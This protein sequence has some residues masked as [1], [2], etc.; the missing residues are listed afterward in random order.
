MTARDWLDWH[1]AYE[2]PGSALSAR[3][4]VVQAEVRRWLDE[5]AGRPSRVVSACAGDGRDL[6]EVLAER[7]AAHVRA[8]LVELDPVLAERARAAAAAAG[9]HGVEVVTGDAGRTAA[10]AG[11]V[12]ADLALVCGVF[13]NTSDD[14]V[15]R[16]V[17]ALGALCAAGGTVVWTRHRRE[18]DLTP[19]VRAWFAGAGFEERAFHSPGAGSWSVGVHRLGV[20]TGAPPPDRLF[21]FA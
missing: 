2:R 21:R 3:L 18:P 5:R 15:R 13:G 12:P 19:A 10:Y 20:G 8:R 9:L 16:T 4:S 17:E 14:D 7:P 6:L 1:V 11:M